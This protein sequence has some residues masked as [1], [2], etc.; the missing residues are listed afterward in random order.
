[1]PF[2]LPALLAPMLAPGLTPLFGPLLA[3]ALQAA[4]ADE[5]KAA[6]SPER[7][8]EVVT[9]LEVAA[10]E[11]DPDLLVAALKEARDV[12][13]REVVAAVAKSLK[14]KDEAVHL[15][16]AE[17]LR[18]LDI[19]DAAKELE[20][21][22]KRERKSLKD[23]TKFYARV[24]RAAAWHGRKST[25][26]VLVDDVWA[27]PDYE[28]IKARVLGLANIRC[29]ESLEALFNLSNK[30]G[31]NKLDPFMDE[32]RLAFAE[33]TGADQGK[34]LDLWWKWWNEN[35]K[36][37]HVAEKPPELP[38]VL[39]L[40]WRSYWGLPTPELDKLRGGGR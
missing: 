8:K 15:E 20:Q 40:R 36:S 10:K 30:A 38:T 37:F 3:L 28:V 19:E 5:A 23:D 11:K 9:G 25:I 7:V 21:F 14:D 32:F 12:P 18:W 33:L 34:S 13:A 29:D 17:T 6:P 35:R 1:M 27:A 2:A 4:P 26:D 16:A 39:D 22:A 31:K 24:L